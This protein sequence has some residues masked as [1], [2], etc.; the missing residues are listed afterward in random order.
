MSQRVAVSVKDLAKIEGSTDTQLN[1]TPT[2]E[3]CATDP[4]TFVCPR[5]D[6]EVVADLSHEP[7]SG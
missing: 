6:G 7:M 5:D 1:R 2:T 3:L 4:Q